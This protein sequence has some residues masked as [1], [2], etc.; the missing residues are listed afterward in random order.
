M[1]G[2]QK[3]LHEGK[4]SPG[5]IIVLLATVLMPLAGQNKGPFPKIMTDKDF[6]FDYSYFSETAVEVLSHYTPGWEKDYPPSSPI[7]ASV[8]YGTS[9]GMEKIVIVLFEGFEKGFANVIFLVE[10]REKAGQIGVMDQLD[11]VETLLIDFSLEDDFTYFENR[12]PQLLHSYHL[13]NKYR[14]QINRDMEA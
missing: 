3:A 12:I 2:G 13:Y 9:E 11:I 5:L 14:D 4:P 8:N 1:R 6:E 7:I 10:D